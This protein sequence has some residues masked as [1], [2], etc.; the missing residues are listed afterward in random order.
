[1]LNKQQNHAIRTLVIKD[2][3]HHHHDH[4]KAPPPPPSSQSQTVPLA[5]GHLGKMRTTAAAGA[6]LASTF[7]LTFRRAWSATLLDRL[8][9]APGVTALTPREPALHLAWLKGFLYP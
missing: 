9:Y 8:M 2:P 3:N 5:N 1:M 7:I 4:H 6:K